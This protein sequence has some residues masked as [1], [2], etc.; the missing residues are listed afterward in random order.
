MN[1][2]ETQRESL[3]IIMETKPLFVVTSRRVYRPDE[4]LSDC[5]EGEKGETAQ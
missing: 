1:T 2:N 3:P 5:R 4:T